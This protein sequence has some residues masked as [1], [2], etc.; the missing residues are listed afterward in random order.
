MISP[1]IFTGIRDHNVSV[2]CIF[3][4]IPQPEV[5]WYKDGKEIADELGQIIPGHNN[6]YIAKLG[7]PDADYKDAGRYLCRGLNPH[8]QAVKNVTLVIKGRKSDPVKNNLCAN[9]TRVYGQGYNQN[10]LYSRKTNA[11]KFTCS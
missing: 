3:N 2:S 9:K 6:T 5:E 11:S 4:G 10:S 8:G 1:S 7:I